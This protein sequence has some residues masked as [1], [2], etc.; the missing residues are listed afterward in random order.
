M[1]TP[2]KK[3]QQTINKNFAQFLRIART[4]TDLNHS[5]ENTQ[6]A[7]QKASDLLGELQE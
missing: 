3:Q 4:T 5:I 6:A 7:Q 2:L 1:K